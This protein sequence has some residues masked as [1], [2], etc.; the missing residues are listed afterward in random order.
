MGGQYAASLAHI[1]GDFAQ[2]I[3]RIAESLQLVDKLM[4]S[5]PV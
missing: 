2:I 1:A 3:G 5:D 4:Q